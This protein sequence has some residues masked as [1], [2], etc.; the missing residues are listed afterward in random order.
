MM[1][2][3]LN[4]S[5][6]ATAETQDIADKVNSKLTLLNVTNQQVQKRKQECIKQFIGELLL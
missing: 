3:G 5:L 2:L 1:V 6:L 4:R